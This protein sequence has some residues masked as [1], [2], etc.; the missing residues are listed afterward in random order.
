MNIKQVLH[1]TVLVKIKRQPYEVVTKSGIILTGIEQ[2]Y[3]IAEVVMIGPGKWEL[4]KETNQEEF[5]PTTLEP[6]DMIVLEK[7]F[8][9]IFNVHERHRIDRTVE[10]K[11]S[12]DEYDYYLTKFQDCYLKFD[13]AEEANSTEIFGELYSV[14]AAKEAVKRK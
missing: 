13:N 8:H 6:G 9:H 7:N 14:M 5:I 1:D 11:Q 4:N 3:F 10:I 2:D 12:D